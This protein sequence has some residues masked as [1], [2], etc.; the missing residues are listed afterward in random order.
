MKHF[1]VTLALRITAALGFLAVALGAFGAHAL[2]RFLTDHVMTETWDKAVFYHLA[3]AVAMLALTNVRPFPR[4]AWLLFL[5]GVLCFSGSLYLY[6]LL[7]FY[8]LVFVTPLGGMFLL[9]GW[10]ALVVQRMAEPQ[11]QVSEQ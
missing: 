7:A 1:S 4:G 8:P 6:A 5:F 9:A 2:K 10:L 3:H 11:V